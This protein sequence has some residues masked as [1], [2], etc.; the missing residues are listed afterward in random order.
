MKEPFSF[1]WDG[2]SQWN[3]EQKSDLPIDLLQS[4]VRMLFWGNFSP[5]QHLLQ[6]NIIRVW[7]KHPLPLHNPGNDGFWGLWVGW[8]LL[9]LCSEQ[10]RLEGLWPQQQYGSRPETCLP[11]A[12]V[13]AQE[14]PG[15]VWAWHCIPSLT[16]SGCTYLSWA[17]TVLTVKTLPLTYIK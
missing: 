16:C 6:K 7:L 8:A 13:L 11:F 15:R 1:G 10:L 5:H 4:L 17:L 2:M 12:A 14:A 3:R 9:T